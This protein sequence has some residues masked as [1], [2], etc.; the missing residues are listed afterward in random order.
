MLIVLLVAA[1][2]LFQNYYAEKVKSAALAEINK[3]LSVEVSVGDIDFT[4]LEK[5]PHAALRFRD[6]VSKQ[7]VENQSKDPLIKAKSV[8]ILFNVWDIILG[9]Y[10]ISKIQLSDAFLTIVDYGEGKNNYQLVEAGSS[11]SGGNTKINIEKIILKN[12]HILYIN[13]P[14]EQEYLLQ[15]AKSELKGQFSRDNFSLQIDGDV[16][17]EHIK[18]GKTTFLEGKD[19][20]LSFLLNVKRKENLYEIKKGKLSVSGLPLTVAGTVKGKQKSRALEL[21]I[22]CEKTKLKTILQEIPSKY[23]KPIK[24]LSVSGRIG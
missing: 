21:T 8:S 12:V 15:V 13:Y 18:S 14:S 1:G 11:G 2:F 7:R 16:F 23:L 19:I 24:D 22:N 17:S 4:L 9:K 5:F 10:E 20:K 3:Q 6:V